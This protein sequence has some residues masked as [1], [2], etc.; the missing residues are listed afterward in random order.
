MKKSNFSQ[1]VREKLKEEVRKNKDA[2][3]E[4]WNKPYVE[5]EIKKVKE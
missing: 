5:Y 4:A 3:D 2:W 1:W